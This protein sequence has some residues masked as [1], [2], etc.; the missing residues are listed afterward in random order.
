MPISF[1]HQI[2]QNLIYAS[3]RR[4]STHINKSFTIGLKNILQSGVVTIDD[5]LHAQQSSDI[6]EGHQ[7][8]L[9]CV[10]ADTSLLHKFRWYVL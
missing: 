8:W 7:C 4:H 2:H 10:P 9:C 6:R 1:E 5:G 3:N